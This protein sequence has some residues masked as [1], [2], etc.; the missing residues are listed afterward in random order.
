MSPEIK[1]HAVSAGI[2]F[3]STFLLF[4]GMELQSLDAETISQGAL[5]GILI[6]GV[7][8]GIKTAVEMFITK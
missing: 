2:T 4:V 8:A 1:R 5:A 7:R 3:T 6:A